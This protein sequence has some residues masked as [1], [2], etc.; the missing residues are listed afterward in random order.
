MADTIAGIVGLI[1]IALIVFIVV[2]I[3]SFKQMNKPKGMKFLKFAGIAFAMMVV[4]AIPY[5][6][7]EKPTDSTQSDKV[8]EKVSTS[9]DALNK[10]QDENKSE[11][12]KHE[13]EINTTNE[14]QVNVQTTVQKSNN[15]DKPKNETASSK[16]ANMTEGELNAELYPAKPGAM[17]Y[18]KTE[19]KFK[20]MEYYFKGEVVGVKSLEGLFGDMEDALLLK[21]D[22]GYVLPVFPPYEID[23]NIGDTVEASGPLSGDGYAASD[24]GVSNVVGMTGAMN[25][26]QISLDGELQ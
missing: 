16:T 2:S 4:L 24:L 3:V 25:A 12:I 18:D 9:T 6:F 10:K 15:T 26:T 11:E 13:Q 1:S 22:Q 21:N 23:V 17:L 14:T 5:S 8:D 19:S 7:L 20:G